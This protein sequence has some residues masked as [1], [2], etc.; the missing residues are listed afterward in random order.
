MRIAI[1][2]MFAALVFGQTP[3]PHRGIGDVVTIDDGGRKLVLLSSTNDGY[4]EMAKTGR[5]HDT[6]GMREM[7]LSGRV[8]VVPVGTLARVI[9]TSF[10]MR[11]VRI[12]TGKKKDAAGW[13]PFEYVK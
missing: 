12:L 7:A 13:L 8:F 1:V 4:D 10:T 11:R 5:A 3:Q 2:L 9:D 6:V